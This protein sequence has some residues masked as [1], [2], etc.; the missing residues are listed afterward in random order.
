[1]IL[2]G[3]DNHHLFADRRAK[4]LRAPVILMQSVVRMR[5]A[6]KL[7]AERRKRLLG[8]IG[9][10][11]GNKITWAFGVGSLVEANYCGQGEWLPGR[12][13]S[14]KD[15]G[16]YCVGYDSGKKESR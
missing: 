11:T 13:V 16:N 1:M 5:L 6:M 4:R 9:L 8:A 12:I 2:E 7:A 15:N 3:M 10:P 14:L